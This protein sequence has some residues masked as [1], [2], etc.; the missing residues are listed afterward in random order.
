MRERNLC[1]GLRRYNSTS[2][3]SPAELPALASTTAAIPAISAL[4]WKISFPRPG[5]PPFSIMGLGTRV[6]E[7]PA[8]P[9]N[10]LTIAAT[11]PVR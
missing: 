9:D 6:S 3:F 1:R 8:F 11:P 5:M 10:A 4:G 2:L 7:R